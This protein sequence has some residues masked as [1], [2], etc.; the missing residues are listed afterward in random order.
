MKKKKRN[1]SLRLEG[2]QT[3]SQEITGTLTDLSE[4]LHSQSSPNLKNL[5]GSNVLKNAKVK[6]FLLML[7]QAETRTDVYRAE[8]IEAPL[9]ASHVICVLGPY[10][11]Q[12]LKEMALDGQLRRSDRV[13][14]AGSRWKPLLE[15]F[16]EW[17]VHVQ[18]HDE[19]SRTMELTQTETMTLEGK[20]PAEEPQ[21]IEMSESLQKKT[22]EKLELEEDAEEW[23]PDT[24]NA[25]P[26]PQSSEKQKTVVSV[27]K[28]PLE[29][30][31]VAVDT[32]RAPLRRPETREGLGPLT[33]TLLI[34]GLIGGVYWLFSAGQKSQEN[35]LLTDQ[36]SGSV[37]ETPIR[38]RIEWPA[39]L[40]P[41]SLESLYEKDSAL[42]RRIRP[43][44]RAYE[45]GIGSLSQADE[46]MLRRMADPASS[47]W[48]MR[49]LAANQLAISYL[50]RGNVSAA[51]ETLTPIFQ[52]SNRDFATLVN[53][54]LID[55]AESRLAQARE[56]FR[57]A[58]R[59][60]RDMQWLSMSLL[61]M[62]EGLSDRWRE[63]NRHFEDALRKDPNN[64][65]IRGLWLQ[66]L[67]KQNKGARFQ[68]QELVREALWSDPD[69][70]IDST[71]PA[72][73][74]GLLIK[75]E[76]LEGLL[77]GAESL[78]PDISSG[79]LS[80]VRWFK[81]RFTTY[82]PLTESLSSVLRQLENENNLQSQ[83]LY[84]Y[85]LKEQG[86]YDEASV[87]LTKSLDQVEARKLTQS[88]WPWTLAGDI[89]FARARYDQAITFFQRALNRNNLD[90]AAVHGLGVT[91]RE[92]GQY[93]DAEQKIRE[94]LALYPFFMPA[95]L[96]VTRLEWHA[97]VR[98]H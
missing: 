21:E 77:K 90:Y 27:P 51:R 10:E 37:V 38:T 91:L 98:A 84:A 72:P 96:R 23:G 5:L 33:L 28:K 42:M 89:M 14:H 68:I 66:T 65:L 62:V 16:P 88:S 56:V 63:A 17:G 35:K 4:D 57:S 36:V 12:H 22:S 41:V 69:S 1:K 67:M 85:A 11:S 18:G 86:R 9:S 50:S 40:Q 61:G 2:E 30:E 32:S 80:F 64:P 78:A 31:K 29:L 48:E 13:L 24:K 8:N 43:I 46:V 93:N 82:S 52:E 15:E 39:S 59:N 75:T 94:S 20:N 97:M 6:K 83:V 55:V 95:R 44:L 87:A 74:A 58:L 71:I 19:F 26:A 49:T 53:M 34:V 79:Q 7:D 25:K 45:S 76:A 92:R 47:S 70:W 81:G 3:E 60:D 73:L 54:G